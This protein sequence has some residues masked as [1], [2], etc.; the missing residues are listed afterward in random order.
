[1]DEA[2]YVGT[3]MRAVGRMAHQLRSRHR[4][5]VTGTPIGSGGLADIQGLLHVLQHDPYQDAFEWR[6]RLANPY[7]R[8]MGPVTWVPRAG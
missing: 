7:L 3:G 1:L 4:W 5:M 2:Q 6:H 8:G